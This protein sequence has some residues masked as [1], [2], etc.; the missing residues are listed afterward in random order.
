[1]NIPLKNAK[2]FIVVGENIHASRVLKLNGKR[3]SENEKGN[4]VILFSDQNG[5]KSFLEIY[6]A[7]S[8]TCTIW[9]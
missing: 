6:R 8:H 9:I 2:D 4:K 7:H 1:M 5:N 3:V